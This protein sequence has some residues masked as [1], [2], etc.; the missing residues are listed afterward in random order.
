[1]I[2]HISIL[3][4]ITLLITITECSGC[5]ILD[6]KIH[7]YLIYLFLFVFGYHMV[8]NRTNKNKEKVLETYVS[9]GDK[10][11]GF[12]SFQGSETFTGRRPGYVFKKGDKG[13]GYYLD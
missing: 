7:S 4:G 5:Y 3:I 2:K 10:K 13:L 12:E 11:V 9:N 1:M 8:S 6:N